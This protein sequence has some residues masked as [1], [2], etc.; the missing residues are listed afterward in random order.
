ML[1]RQEEMFSSLQN[2]S[3]S[4]SFGSAAQK[5]SVLFVCEVKGGLSFL[6]LL[7]PPPPPPASKQ[8]G[9]FFFWRCGFFFFM[10]RMF[11]LEE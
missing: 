11:D 8:Q 4:S 7:P 6:F 1:L 10:P 5:T 2:G 3:L 9:G